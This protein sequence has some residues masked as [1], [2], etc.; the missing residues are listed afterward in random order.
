MNRYKATSTL[1]LAASLTTLSVFVQVVEPSVDIAEELTK[2]ELPR[3]TPRSVDKMT[4][5][6][7]LELTKKAQ[8]SIANMRSFKFQNHSH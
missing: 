8:N 7:I 1:F 4:K 2:T 3:Q 5:S 6:E